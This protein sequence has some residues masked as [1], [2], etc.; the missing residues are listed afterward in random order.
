[1]LEVLA[2]QW[3]I[4][5]PDNIGGMLPYVGEVVLGIRLIMDI[6][7]TERDMKDVVIQDRSRVHALKALTLM[8]RFGITSVCVT[9]GGAA[10]SLTV[11][12]LGSAVGSLAGGGLS[13]YLNRRLRPHMLEIAMKLA[14]ISEDD[15]FYFQNKSTIDGIGRSLAET[16]A[17]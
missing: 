1:M 4:D 9:L 10:G 16:H 8:S 2:Q 17:V 7:S 12:G 5:L 14:G 6:I 3:G 15:L 13:F 11:P